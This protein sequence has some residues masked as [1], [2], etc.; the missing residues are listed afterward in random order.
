M[1]K[2][3][4]AAVSEQMQTIKQ[5]SAQNESLTLTFKVSPVLSISDIQGKSSLVC[6]TFKVGVD[7]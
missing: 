4:S 6:L 5:L 7:I 3:K 2:E 1:S